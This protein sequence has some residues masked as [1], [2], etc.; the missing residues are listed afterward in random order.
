MSNMQ[1]D[2]SGAS[3]KEILSLYS[4]LARNPDKA[5]GWDKGRENARALGYE[6][7]WLERLPERVWESAAAVGNPFSLGSIRPGGV[8]VD[9]GCGAGADLCVSALLVGAAG[10]V[11]GIDLTPAI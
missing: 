6:A 5:F 4:E 7:G 9:L 10:C 3:L 8:E 1:S 2:T 11:I